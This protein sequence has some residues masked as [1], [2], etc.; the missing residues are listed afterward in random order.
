MQATN[1]FA[2]HAQEQDSVPAL[3]ERVSTLLDRLIYL[4]LITIITF[5]A[6][7]YG[8]VDAWWVSIFE[9][10]VFVLAALWLT[11]GALNGSWGQ[12]DWLLGVPLAALLLFAFV[13]TLPLWPDSTDTLAVG[14][15][16]IALSADPYETRLWILY[17]CAL[18]L[19]GALLARYT[20]SERRIKVLVVTVIAIGVASAIFGILRHVTHFPLPLMESRSLGTDGDYG[21]YLN[22]NH[23]ALLMEMALGLTSGFV[24]VGLK[25]LHVILFL[26]IGTLLWC[27]LVLSNSRGGILSMI[28]QV[29]FL[30]ALWGVAR[31]KY[32]GIKVNGG[33]SDRFRRFVR[34]FAARAVI[35]LCLVAT[36]AIG[37]VWLGGDAL[38][39]RLEFSH[40]EIEPENSTRVNAR[41]LAIWQATISMIRANPIAGIGFAGYRT[42]IPAYH[43]AS[44]RW[45]PKQ[46]H[47]EY[48]ELMASGGLI[49]VAFVAW[50]IGNLGKK[51]WRRLTLSTD[52]F[53]RA[54]CIGALVGI[55]GVAVHSL[56]DFGLHVTV[57]ALICIS[58]V[59]I[60]TRRIEKSV[61][62][63]RRPLSCH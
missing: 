59:V 31:T 11:H 5:A 6:I 39:H 62:P 47:N 43:D 41:R 20:S 27:A 52:S 34:S 40:R 58:L 53:A 17:I 63:A 46:A 13:Q 44:G 30:T 50:F 1:V 23:F 24:I 21:Q 32:K 37:V 61:I 3:R 60:A 15:P 55:F 9:C 16:R 57:N 4:G 26:S 56:F 33:G 35:G 49:G 2:S 54:T 12:F 10:G 42:A 7:P 22:R 14:S 8:T 29:L 28:G 36:L 48:L 38:M 19:V 45:E 51:A 18:S 25:R